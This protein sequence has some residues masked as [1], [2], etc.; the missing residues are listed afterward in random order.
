[1]CVYVHVC[2]HGVG[3][4]SVAKLAMMS[5]SRSFIVTNLQELMISFCIES[6]VYE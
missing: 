4:I 5:L 6:H 2:L 1:M 3:G